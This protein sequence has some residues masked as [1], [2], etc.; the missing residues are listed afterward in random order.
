M[1]KNM[2]ENFKTV[3]AR[4][5]GVPDGVNSGQFGTGIVI[6]FFGLSSQASG[7][8]VDF[9]YPKLTTLVPAN[10]AIIKNA[11]NKKQPVPLSSIYCPQ[12]DKRSC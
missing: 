7:F 1:M 4:S 10:I 6:D 11:P 8:P 9:I 12:L 5:F 3:T 2:A